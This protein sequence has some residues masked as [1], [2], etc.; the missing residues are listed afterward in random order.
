MK[1]FITLIFLF[2]LFFKTLGQTVK[3]SG[4]V[5]YSLTMNADSL[6]KKKIVSG[7]SIKTV[8]HKGQVLSTITNFRG[9]SLKSILDEAQIEMSSLK[10]RGVYF[11]L[12]TSTDGV[13]VAFTWNEIYSSPVGEKTLILFENNGKPLSNDWILSLICTSDAFTEARH[14]KSIKTIEVLKW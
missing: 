10:D 1:L 6:K 13:K 4:L 3:L 11:I 2:F 5:K 9:V 8:N 7:K 14:I 12:V